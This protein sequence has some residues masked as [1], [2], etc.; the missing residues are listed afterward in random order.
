MKEQDG[1][2]RTPASDAT[3]FDARVEFLR[4]R[5]GPGDEAIETHHAWVFLAGD[6]AWKL[7]K[8]IRRDTMDY[9]TLEARERN[10]RAEVRLNRRLAPGMYLS[11]R[12]LVLDA[13]GRL[14]VGGAGRVVDW[15]V[16]MR[17]LDRSLA[18]DECL[19]NGRCEERALE[20][21]VAHLA[22]FYATQPPAITDGR[23]LVHR[24]LGL[25]TA[26]REPLATVDAEAATRLH[27]LQMRVLRE[28]PHLFEA[29][30]AQGCIV[31]AHGDLRPEHVILCDPPVVI[32]CLEFDRNLRILDRAEELSFLALECARLGHASVGDRL[33]RD[34][35]ERLGDDASGPLLAWYRSHRA[36]TR[37]K[38]WAWRGIE[39]GG[40]GAAD[41]R[42]RARYYVDTALAAAAAAA[43]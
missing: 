33:V 11:V 12:R 1:P 37:A 42:G 3:E 8:P 16:E 23:H 32:D 43:A 40:A 5:L 22:R 35:L 14:A 2:M 6:R 7:R 26:N 24:L 9:S 13:S 31:E 15:L 10:A 17:R 36:A 20:Q 25:V 34:C 4:R 19:A 41:W 38:L 29:R 30:A 27:A 28:R 39:P 21:V 18:L